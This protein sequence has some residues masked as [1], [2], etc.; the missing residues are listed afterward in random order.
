[1]SRVVMTVA[2]AL[3]AALA[4]RAA[5]ACSCAT[6]RPQLLATTPDGTFPAALPLLVSSPPEAFLDIEDAA[7]TPMPTHRVAQFPRLGLCESPF[8]LVAF[9]ADPTPPG[10]YHLV[11]S[12][13]DA[14]TFVLTAGEYTAVSADLTLSLTVETHDPPI[15]P[16]GSLCADPKI[17]GRSFSRTAHLSFALAARAAAAPLILTATVADPQTPDGL[18]QTT[19]VYPL[20]SAGPALL[21]LPLEDSVDACA[22]LT[23][24]DGAGRIAL[25][26]RLCATDAPE[27][28]HTLRTWTIVPLVQPTGLE[29]GRGC[30]VAGGDRRPESAL[31]FLSALMLIVCAWRP[32]PRNANTS[33][34]TG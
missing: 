29:R 12:P 16:A 27:T 19:L 3:A 8:F 32:R 5:A 33:T 4:P 2:L 1:M 26:D 18:A 17:S 21:E 7:G 13:T 11:R 22:D 30:A 15:I 31:V 10:E 6:P 24:M 25:I 28:T 9:D 34:R 14:P 20:D 23:A